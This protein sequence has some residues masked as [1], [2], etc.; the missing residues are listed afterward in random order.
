CPQ[1]RRRDV[2]HRSR[3]RARMRTW[4]P[5]PAPV[6]RRTSSRRFHCFTPVK[7]GVDRHQSVDCNSPWVE[8]WRRAPPLISG[9]L[10]AL[11]ELGVRS[12]C[13]KYYPETRTEF[14]RTADQPRRPMLK[15][16]HTCG[17]LTIEHV[18]QTVILNGWVDA[19]RDFGGLTFIDVRDRAGLTQVV[20]EP[21]AGAELQNAAREL[22]NE[23]VI[24]VKGVVA[25]R[26]AGK[27]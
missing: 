19:W 2:R 8:P 14:P 25:P 15:R 12:T 4:R 3:R 24:G 13:E 1:S 22:R 10:D 18:G 9:V 21:E 20:F 17:E 16:T 23:Y 27:T 5:T 6:P 7:Q 26:L 11:P